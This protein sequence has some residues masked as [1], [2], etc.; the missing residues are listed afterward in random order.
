MTLLESLCRLVGELD[1]DNETK[2]RR[3]TLVLAREGIVVN[4]IRNQSFM[5]YTSRR[6]VSLTDL[7]TAHDPEG[8]VVENIRVV[9]Q[10]LTFPE[11]RT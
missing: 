11:D 3:I 1:D 10:S 7:E 4:G 8:L 9:R 6:V 5:T 2:P